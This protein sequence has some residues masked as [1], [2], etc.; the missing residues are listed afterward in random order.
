METKPFFLTSE[1]WVTVAVVVTAL[2]GVLP[3]GSR[4]AT[5]C[6]TIVTAAYALSRG[7]AKAGVPVDTGPAVSTNLEAHTGLNDD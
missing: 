1:W 2:S 5:V 6:A 3:V 7:L 4:A